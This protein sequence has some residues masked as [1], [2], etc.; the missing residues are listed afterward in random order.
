MN[1][2]IEKMLAEDVRRRARRPQPYDPLI[3]D[4]SDPDRVQLTAPDGHRAIVP[5]YMTT[6]PAIHAVKTR[7]DFDSLRM[8][9]DFEFWAARCVKIKDKVTGADIPFVL[10]APQRRVLAAL[11]NDRRAGRPI[12]VMILKARQWG[13]ST[14]VQIYMAWIQ[15]CLR[16]NW[17]SLI[18]SQVKDTSSGIRGMYAKLLDNYPEEFWPEGVKPAFRPYERSTN[19]REITG[20]GCRVTVSSIENQDAVRGADFAM[21]H[22]SET[23]F[24]RATPTHSPDDVIRA[25][26]GSVA[27]LPLTLVVMEST[28]NGTGNYFHSEWLRCRDGR[29]DKHTVFVPWY[30]IEMYRLEPADPEALCASF[31]EYERRLWTDFGLALDQINWYRH[32]RREYPSHQ[33]MMAEY[34]TTDDEAFASTAGNVFSRAAV[35]SLRA[36]CAEGR[37][38]EVTAGADA[39]P[40]WADDETGRA[41]LWQEPVPGGVYVVAVDIGGRTAKADWSVAVVMRTDGPLPEVVAQWRGHIDHDLL[42]GVAARMGMWYNDALLAIESNT[43]ESSGAGYGAFIL[44]RLA[45]SYPNLYCRNIDTADCGPARRPG[46]HTNRRT[47]ELIISNLI[48]QVRDG[49]YI[50]R[51]A[52]ACDELLTYQTGADGSYAAKP[53]CHDD[54]LMTR[55]MAL[56]VAGTECAPA[57]DCSTY[58]PRPVQ[59]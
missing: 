54:M 52:A 47:K 44:Q 6:D 56:Y 51:C 35:E 58:R 7:R 33:K 3:G 5:R 25:V 18:C 4:A 45:D 19:V 1:K 10:N 57:P 24:W 34:P 38:G 8:C 11:E 43:L 59:W 13:G 16:P 55:A 41:T 36:G 37:C 29:G 40:V 26:C 9:H 15:M 2:D 31:D 17:H 53:G 14:L 49:R 27:L 23:A 46:F 22:L 28:A 20:R 12:R 48:E 42:A 39:L 21:A 30:E 32:K 50:E